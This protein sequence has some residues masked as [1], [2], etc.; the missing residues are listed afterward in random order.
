MPVAQKVYK[1]VLGILIAIAVTKL[2]MFLAPFAPAV[3]QGFSAFAGAGSATTG[4]INAG[5][6]A[7]PLIMKALSAAGVKGV[8]DGT[9]NIVELTQKIQHLKGHEA[10]HEAEGIMNQ[11]LAKAPS[12]IDAVVA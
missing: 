1:V 4:T 3:L 5:A 6:V 2:I 11:E 8:A 10:E 12:E 9:C 7:G